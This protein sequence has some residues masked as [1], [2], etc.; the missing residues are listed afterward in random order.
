MCL[1]IEKKPEHVIPKKLLQNFWERN[2]DGWGI[3]IPDPANNDVI[4][5]KG[6][7]QEGL[8]QNLQTVH[9]DGKLAYVHVR[10]RTHGEISEAMNHPFEVVKNLWLMHN[11]VLSS[12]TP[13]GQDNDSDS[14]RFAKCFLKLILAPLPPEMIKDYIRTEEFKV[15]VENQIGK[16]SN[17]VVLVDPHGGIIFNNS[18]WYT[19]KKGDSPHAEGMLVSNDYSW[20]PKSKPV[21]VYQGNQTTHHSYTPYNRDRDSWNNSRW[22]NRQAANR[23]AFEGE[24][25]NGKKKFPYVERGANGEMVTTYFETYEAYNAHAIKKAKEANEGTQN[26]KQKLDEEILSEYIDLAKTW[27]ITQFLTLINEET[28]TAADL[29]WHYVSKRKATN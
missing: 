15:L 10:K 21:Y 27:S 12:Y 2:K 26:I 8:R 20:T 5:L 19:L 22:N 1:I 11:G 29:L 6:M 28:D 14:L 17:R 13:T 4:I 9:N 24:W 23:S 25:V 16:F 18:L 7:T 3:A